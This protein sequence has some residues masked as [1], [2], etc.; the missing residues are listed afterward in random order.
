MTD[1]KD[2]EAADPTIKMPDDKTIVDVTKRRKWRRATCATALALLA[3]G[4]VAT[5]A[6]LLVDAYNHE[7]HAF[8]S[9][10]STPPQGSNLS[11]VLNLSTDSSGEVSPEAFTQSSCRS[12]CFIQAWKDRTNGPNLYWGWHAGYGFCL[13]SGVGTTAGLYWCHNH[14]WNQWWKFDSGGQLRTHDTYYLRAS[15]QGAWVDQKWDPSDINSEEY[16]WEAQPLDLKCSKCC[17]HDH[18]SYTPPTSYRSADYK[19][20][21]NEYA[22]KLVTRAEGCEGS[23]SYTSSRCRNE[24]GRWGW[25]RVCTEE[26][27]G[28]ELTPP[29]ASVSE[30]EGGRCGAQL[31]GAVLLKHTRSGMCLSVP[32]SSGQSASMQP[33]SDSDD[34]QIFRMGTNVDVESL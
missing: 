33:C 2:V 8:R 3:V 17:R 6:P 12:G 13:D 20:A 26:T 18:K 14:N 28:F 32:V 25:E 9:Y 4:V 23:G 24:W 10:T 30:L 22:E 7:V 21:K 11:V 19:C 5:A 31:A 16:K 34:K 27:R 1:T 15:P 29:D